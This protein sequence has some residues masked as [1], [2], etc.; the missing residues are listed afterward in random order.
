MSTEKLHLWRMHLGA[1][2]TAERTESVVVIGLLMKMMSTAGK[3]NPQASDTKQSN[4][5]IHVI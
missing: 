2:E 5:K 3:S 4:K 1:M